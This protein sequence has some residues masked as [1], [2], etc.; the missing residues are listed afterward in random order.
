MPLVTRLDGTQYDLKPLGIW[1]QDFIVSAPNYRHVTAQVTGANGLVVQETTF[2]ERTITM[3]V[4][5]RPAS[6]A[7]YTS[8]RNQ[9][10]SIFRSDEEF[11]ISDMRD[12]SKRWLVKCTSFSDLAQKG[13]YGDTTIVFTCYRGFAEDVNPVLIIETG[14]PFIVT[15]N[16]NIPIDPTDSS[17]PDFLITVKGPSNNLTINNITTGESFQYNT[18]MNSDDILTIK[19]VQLLK[20]GVSDYGNCNGQSISLAKGQ[21]TFSISGYGSPFEIDFQFTQLFLGGSV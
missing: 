21:N 15:N 19:N 17:Q 6:F 5:I 20:N 11:Y 10:F 9:V 12:P 2:G 14:S 3:P 16:G 4:R 18:S 1:A 13:P 7:A 8:L